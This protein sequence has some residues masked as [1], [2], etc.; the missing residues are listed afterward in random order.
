MSFW[1]E[2]SHEAQGCQRGGSDRTTWASV[3]ARRAVTLR[4]VGFRTLLFR[5][6]LDDSSVPRFL[7]V[8]IGFDLFPRAGIPHLDLF[9]A[10]EDLFH[11]F[12]IGHDL[13]RL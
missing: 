2:C 10:L 6:R 5:H 12:R 4:M 8:E 7:E 3:G 9:D 13:N 1:G 11:K